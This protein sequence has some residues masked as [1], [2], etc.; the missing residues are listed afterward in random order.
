MYLLCITPR[1]SSTK[2]F[3]INLN[4]PPGTEFE[5]Y[6]GHKVINISKVNLSIHQTRALEKGLTF[7]PT[8]KGADKSEIWNDFKEFHRR[9]ELAQFFKP[10]NEVIDSQLT[11]SIIDF[12]NENAGIDTPIAP[13][14]DPYK[15]IYRPFRNKSS[16]KPNPP[17]RTVDTFK[18]AFKNDLLMSNNHTHIQPNLTKEEWKGLLE[19][20]KKP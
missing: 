1:C 9:I 10:I 12:M 7:C 2:T 16:W 6:I 11:Q 8:P 5:S 14:N 20:R 13:D 19:L 3:L 15:H 17:N 4:L 18:R